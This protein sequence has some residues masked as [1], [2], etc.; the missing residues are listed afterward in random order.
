[1]E[2]EDLWASDMIIEAT[3]CP[4]LNMR[5]GNSRILLKGLGK[6]KK[7]RYLEVNNYYSKYD[8]E[9][10]QKFDDTSQLDIPNSLKYLNFAHYPFL[11]LPKTFQ[12]NNLV[13]L[14]MNNSRMVQLWK[15]GEKKVLKKLKFLYLDKSNLKI[16]DFRITPNLEKLS[17]HECANLVELFMPV[18]CQN[19]K[20]LHIGCSKL[21]T[22]DLGLT[23]NLE[24]LSLYYSTQFAKLRVS[25]ACPNLKF[26]YLNNLRLRSLDLEL[27]PNLEKLD[28]AEC[29]ELVEINAPAGCLKKV[30]YLNIRDCLRFTD[31]KFHGRSEPKVSRSSPSLDLVGESLDLCPLHPKSN[32]LKLKFRCSYYEYL[33]SSVRNIEK[34]ISFGLYLGKL[35]CLEELCLSCMKIKHLPD[36]ICMLKRLKSL[37]IDYG[38]HLEKLP[39]DLGQLEC[40]EKLYVSSKKIEYLPDSICMLKRLKWLIVTKCCLGKLPDD[41]G[42][43][44]SLEILALWGTTIKHLPD[45]ICMLK[46]L[47]TINVDLCALLEKLPEDLGQL[48]CLEKLNIADTCISHL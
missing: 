38:D 33:P 4:R 1:E 42:Q 10:D 31:L 15:K 18:C 5:R 28:L 39:E 44:E 14:I 26:L 48:E 21:I 3:M 2:I 16:F 7:L 12:G 6:M 46:H 13:G 37:T 24:T 27:I 9:R 34:L 20:F 8:C 43:L 41:I 23:P 29:R 25:V 30:D 36:S 35:E 32:L 19:L 11:Y 22:F 47:K 45:S 40:L 17:S